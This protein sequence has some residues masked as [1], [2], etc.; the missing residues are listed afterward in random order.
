MPVIYI[1]G[2]STVED[3]KPPFRGWGWAI[4]AHTTEGVRVEN[5]AMSG[6]SSRSFMDEGRFVIVGELKK[7][8]ACKGFFRA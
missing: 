5:H 3:N 2:D 6:R 7:I 4:P 1:I 8:E